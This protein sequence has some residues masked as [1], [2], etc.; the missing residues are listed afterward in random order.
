M[1]ITLLQ[2]D[3]NKTNCSCEQGSSECEQDGNGNPVLYCDLPTN[4]NS[5][6]CKAYLEDKY[7][8]CL[9]NY[10][11]CLKKVSK[12]NK[13]ISGNIQPNMFIK[14]HEDNNKICLSSEIFNILVSKALQ[15]C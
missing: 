1:D 2:C 5:D 14:K 11:D 15:N 6:M 9:P 10:D 8:E 7:S 4:K 12:Y 13:Q 3:K